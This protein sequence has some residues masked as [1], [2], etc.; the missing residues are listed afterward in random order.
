MAVSASIILDDNPLATAGKGNPHGIQFRGIRQLRRKVTF[1]DTTGTIT[2][3][4][5]ISHIEGLGVAAQV[6]TNTLA[7]GSVAITGAAAET[8]YIV[9][10]CTN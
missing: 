3:P 9:I 1:D 5:R 4:Y 8:Y 7:G 6:V 2:A 10:I